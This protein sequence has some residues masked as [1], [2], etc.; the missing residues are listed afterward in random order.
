VDFA[1]PGW[2]PAGTRSTLAPSAVAS[3]S[4]LVCAGAGGR[5]QFPGAGCTSL[6]LAPDGGNRAI[7]FDGNERETLDPRLRYG[8]KQSTVLF[9]PA[10]MLLANII[11]CR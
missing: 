11:Q 10:F 6:P 4:R 3:V 2:L 1:G 8:A 9:G 5:S 7:Q